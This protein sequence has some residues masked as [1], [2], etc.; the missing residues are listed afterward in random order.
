MI[1]GSISENKKLEKRISI[2]PETAKKYLNLGFKVQ[3]SEKYGDHLGF[4]ENEY[5]ELGVKFI[6]DDKNLIESSDIIIQMSLFDEDKASLLK[7]N[8]TFIGVLN[9]YQNKNKL[10][11]LAKKK[12]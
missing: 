6:N 4:N 5:K 8:Q 10:N 1:I 2:T 7:S 3:L 11:E 12:N 9:P